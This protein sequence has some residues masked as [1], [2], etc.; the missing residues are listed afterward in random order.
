[1]ELLHGAGAPET[2]EAWVMDALAK[3]TRIMGFGHRIYKAGDVRAGILKP[4]ARKLAKAAGFTKEEGTA[5]VIEQIMA[6]E[7]NLHPNLDWP[8]GRLY[9][10]LG[11][12]N[13]IY[14]PVFVMSRI[15]GWS[16][17]IIEQH[18]HNRLIRPRSKYVGPATRAVPKRK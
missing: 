7:K 6:R 3:K 17:H 1:M 14:T 4:I 12:E 5:E 2:A 11:L 16:A 13:S 18:E 9:N 15:A 8:A 10:A